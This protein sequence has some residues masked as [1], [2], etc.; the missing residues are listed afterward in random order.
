MAIEFTAV[1][2]VTI[3]QA[4]ELRPLQILEPQVVVFK[5]APAAASVIYEKDGVLYGESREGIHYEIGK[6]G[7][8]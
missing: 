2:G 8:V 1:I 5:D 3:N 7:K 6:A 4:L